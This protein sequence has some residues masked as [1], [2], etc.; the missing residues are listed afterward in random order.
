MTNPA[1]GLDDDPRT[2][3]HQAADFFTRPG[4]FH[5]LDIDIPIEDWAG[6]NGTLSARCVI[7]FE[8]QDKPLVVEILRQI[9]GALAAHITLTPAQAAG[10]VRHVT[11]P[12]NGE[13]C[14]CDRTQNGC[15]H[16]HG[17]RLTPI[18]MSNGHT[19]YTITPATRATTGRHAKPE[20][21]QA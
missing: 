5:Q 21:E 17:G 20:G 1:T 9:R 18:P 7:K 14:R 2:P 16:T 13:P 12:V 3:D 6:V 15:P 4:D 19:A 10:P 11:C 8:P